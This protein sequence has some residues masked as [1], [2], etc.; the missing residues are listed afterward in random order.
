L[1]ARLD[2]CA[3]GDIT[4]VLG[5][6]RVPPQKTEGL[7]LSAAAMNL[8][9]SLERDHTREAPVSAHLFPLDGFD[10]VETGESGLVNITD[11]PPGY[12]MTVRHE[13]DMVVLTTQDGAEARVSA[14]EWTD[15]VCAFADEVERFY[16]AAEPKDTAQLDWYEA[17]W[18]EWRERRARAT[19]SA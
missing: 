10:W 19:A 13:S 1:D 18:Q 15:V 8:L 9:R 17:F 2:P 14:A 5:G 12:D 6:E 3:H 16:E 7:C 11:G 4:L